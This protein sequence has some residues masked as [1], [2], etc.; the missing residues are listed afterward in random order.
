M[1]AVCYPY[2]RALQPDVQNVSATFNIPPSKT[3]LQ[4]VRILF[5]NLLRNPSAFTPFTA[6]AS[7]LTSLPCSAGLSGTGI[8]TISE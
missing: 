5:T 6:A 4:A 8:G 1:L 2:P 7:G 3:I